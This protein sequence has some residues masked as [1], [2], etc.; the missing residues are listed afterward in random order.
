MLINLQPHVQILFQ[1]SALFAMSSTIIRRVAK[2]VAELLLARLNQKVTFLWI[3]AHTEVYGN[4]LK[5]T[6]ETA[7]FL[8]ILD[9][10][11]LTFDLKK[12]IKSGL[13]ALWQRKWQS[14]SPN[15]KLQQIKHS[16][17]PRMTAAEMMW[18]SSACAMHILS[19]KLRLH[20]VLCVALCSAFTIA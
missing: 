20:C 5:V 10:P 19:T 12:C 7:T 3:P 8:S 6:R 17:D 13:F 1:H 18:S 2:K 15:N 4:E 16:I 9:V 14:T 11:M